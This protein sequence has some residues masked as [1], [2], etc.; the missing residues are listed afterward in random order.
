MDFIN[1]GNS[2]EDFDITKKPHKCHSNAHDHE[3]VTR[4]QEL[5]DTDSSKS[6]RAM[7]HELDVSATLVRK[8]VKED[9]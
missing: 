9:L 3:I 2:P 7:A 5:V 8:I 4:V 1:A 6:M